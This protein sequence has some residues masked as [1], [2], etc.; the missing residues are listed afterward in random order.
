MQGSETP[1]SVQFPV[2]TNRL[3]H[4]RLQRLILLQYQLDCKV[5]HRD[6]DALPQVDAMQ[7]AGSQQLHSL[8]QPTRQPSLQLS[9]QLAMQDMQ[10]Q[11]QAAQVQAQ[12]QGKT[13]SGEPGPET[14]WM[15]RANSVRRAMYPL[16]PSSRGAF[17]GPGK[18]YVKAEPGLE[19]HDSGSGVCVSVHRGRGSALPPAQPVLVTFLCFCGQLQH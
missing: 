17:L 11:A 2:L 5:A 19:L 12:M 1:S 9:Q 7:R 4:L 16:K 8:H 18:H 15:E 6:I 14:S 3:Q 13:S 10:R